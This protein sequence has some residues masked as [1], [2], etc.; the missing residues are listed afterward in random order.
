M[1]WIC[2]CGYQRADVWRY[3]AGGAGIRGDSRYR[4][5]SARAASATEGTAVD[6]DAV[7]ESRGV[8]WLAWLAWLARRRNPATHSQAQSM[9]MPL[10]GRK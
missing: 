6:S 10:N 4:G 5:A 2:L 7:L 3:V 9:K 8:V 1:P